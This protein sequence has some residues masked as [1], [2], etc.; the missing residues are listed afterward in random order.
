MC[1]FIGL[2]C[3]SMVFGMRCFVNSNPAQCSF[4]LK[5]LFFVVVL[6]EKSYIWA[7]NIISI[8]AVIMLLSTHYII[9]FIWHCEKMLDHVFVVSTLYRLFVTPHVRRTAK[10]LI[11]F[12]CVNPMLS[13]RIYITATTLALFYSRFSV[14]HLE[15]PS[16]LRNFL[17]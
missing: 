8:S 17:C 11:K 16:V 5:F 14:N 2:L 12:T 13:F 15:K 1:S 4:S 10:I 7:D 6:I 3:C 9:R